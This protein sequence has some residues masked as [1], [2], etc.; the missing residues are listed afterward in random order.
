MYERTD[1]TTVR[2]S[3]P[4]PLELASAL[5]GAV[6]PTHQRSLHGP[7]PLQ[8]AGADE[9]GRNAIPAGERVDPYRGA[10]ACLRGHVSHG[11]GSTRP[12]PRSAER[13]PPRRG[14]TSCMASSDVGI[15]SH[16][17]L[18]YRCAGRDRL[19]GDACCRA[20]IRTAEPLESLAWNAI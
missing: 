14:S 18:I 15:P 6:P 1:V 8:P 9:Q 7:R 5:W 20:A 12:E 16:G 2:W 19:T 17:H 10:G 4:P 3:T 11:P 13:A